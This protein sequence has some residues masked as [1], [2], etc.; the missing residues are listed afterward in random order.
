MNRAYNLNCVDANIIIVIGSNAE[1]SI[2]LV[3][4][5]KGWETRNYDG[6]LVAANWCL[7]EA[8]GCREDCGVADRYFNVLNLV[9]DIVGVDNAGEDCDNKVVLGSAYDAAVRLL[10]AMIIVGDVLLDIQLKVVDT[11][12]VE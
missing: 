3:V 7:S 10:E 1:V 9:H 5:G 11:N 6:F 8:V 4:R 2:G 12:V